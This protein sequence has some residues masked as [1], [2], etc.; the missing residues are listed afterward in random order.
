ME[1][2]EREPVESLRAPTFLSDSKGTS[3]WLCWS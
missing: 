1:T 2:P 3:L